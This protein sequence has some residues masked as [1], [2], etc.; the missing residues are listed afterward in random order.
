MQEKS[1]F[2]EQNTSGR[3]GAP[4]E[5]R[6]TCM[7]EVSR[8]RITS[9]PRL[10]CQ[11]LCLVCASLGGQMAASSEQ[12]IILPIAFKP[13]KNDDL[14][15]LSASLTPS[16]LWDTSI[17]LNL[18]VVCP[19]DIQGISIQKPSDKYSNSQAVVLTSCCTKFYIN[20]QKSA[21]AISGMSFQTW[22]FDVL[23]MPVQA[24]CT[25]VCTSSNTYHI[26]NYIYILFWNL[27]NVRT[28]YIQ[29]QILNTF[30]RHFLLGSRMSGFLCV[31]EA[32][33]V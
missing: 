1:I 2:I 17:T 18:A 32:I 13:R 12:L 24:Q 25:H 22:K 9:R 7:L 19:E 8:V 26:L 29:S 33:E 28:I 30:R 21:L 23:D 10:F 4:T 6:M 3:E 20:Q 16:N 11:E 14:P 15:P 27:Y 5:W 31:S